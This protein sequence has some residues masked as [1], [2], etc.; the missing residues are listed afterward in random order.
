MKSQYKR[1]LVDYVDSAVGDI[2]DE[3]VNKYYSDKI[4]RYHDYEKL[5]YAIAREIKKEVLKGKGTINDIIAYLERLRSKRNVAS[6]ILSY[7][8]G[9]VL[10]KEE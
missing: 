8:I 7:F 9:K 5:L 1:K 2:I 6:L 4:E 3:L 10:N